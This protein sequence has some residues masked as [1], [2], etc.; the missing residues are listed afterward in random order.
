MSTILEYKC[1]CCGGAVSFDSTQQKM[2]CPYCDAE[3]DIEA[4]KNLQNENDD[5]DKQP[6]RYEWDVQPGN[7]WG[8]DE[9]KGINLYT[10][11]SCGGELIADENTGATN[12]P[13]CDNP[14]ILKSSFSGDLRPDFV[15]PF[16]LDKKAAKAAMENHLKGKPFLP[17]VFKDQNH[18]DE[19]KGI[20][21]PFWLFD[22]DTYSKYTFRGTKVR[23]WSDSKYDYTETSHFNIYREGCLAF[24]N[25][26]VDGSEKMP[27]D[28]MESIEPF[29][30]SQMV[31]FETAYL[32]GYLAD[33]YDVDQKS[34]IGRANN[35]IK[36]S[37]EEAFKR[38]VH[39]YATVST[40]G[41]NVG[42]YKS[43]AHYA[44][45]PV[46]I[47]NTTW[48]NQKFMFAMNGQTGKFVGDLP[49]DKGLFWKWFFGIFAISGAAASLLTVLLTIIR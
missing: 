4:L 46:W 42:F 29:D 39:G 2:V 32:A 24:R 47:L 31:D 5:S 6:E 18:I 28:F 3:F 7:Q 16:K 13:Y 8:E 14:V 36:Q 44:L 21:V 27:D 11:Q 40:A 38:T 19:I 17:K 12:C 10:C 15:I 22:C 1:P 23:H 30:Y 33:K 26:P 25:V 35:R 9:L 43:A 34:S 48:K 49:T 37:T 20:Y 45:L 41:S